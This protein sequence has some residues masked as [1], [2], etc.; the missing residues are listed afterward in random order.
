MALDKE[1]PL[2]TGVQKYY[3]P[4]ARATLALEQNNTREKIE[5]LRCLRFPQEL[6]SMT[7]LD[8]IYMRGQAYIMLHN[9]SAAASESHKVID[10]PGIGSTATLQNSTFVVV[11]PFRNSFGKRIGDTA[12][13]AASQSDRWSCSTNGGCS[14]LA[15][16]SRCHWAL[17]CKR[18]PRW[19]NF[20]DASIGTRPL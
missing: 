4:T 7:L 14:T 17:R 9:G 20:L 5:L 3:L 8:P 1:F 16:A 19:Q 2:D 12:R 18:N 10:H 11:H 6:G 15:L 13:C